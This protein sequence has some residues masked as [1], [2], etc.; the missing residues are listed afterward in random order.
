MNQP[1]SLMFRFCPFCGKEDIELNVDQSRYQCQNCHSVCFINSKLSVCAVIVR[2]D[3]ILLVSDSR[4]SNALWDFPGG[5]LHYG[6]EPEAG[7][8]REL[9]EE[10]GVE[11]RV[12]RLLSAEVDTYSSD[13]DSCL[14]L[15]YAAQLLSETIRPGEEIKKA[16]WFKLDGLPRIRFKSTQHVISSL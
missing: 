4:E 10:L 7:L 6:E 3:K 8:R 13:S 1:D 12:G 15:F 16:K 14:N 9:Q 2:N 11:A 5:F